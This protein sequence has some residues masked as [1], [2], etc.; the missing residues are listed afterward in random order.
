MQKRI[1]DVL[2]RV[3]KVCREHN[4]T[5]YLS[6][7]T[8]LGAIRHGGFI[9]WDDDA[10][11]AMPREDYERFIEHG[12]EWLPEPLE[13][14]C[15]EKN[16]K[17]SCTFLKIIDGSTTLIERW[18]YNQLGGVYIDIFPYDGVAPQKWR[19][20]VRFSLFR[21]LK[22]WIYLRNRDPYKRGHGYT[23]WLPRILQATVSNEKLQR[24]LKR[25]QTKRDYATSPLVADFD[26]GERSVMPREVL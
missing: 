3:D 9:P 18:G 13:L 2:L 7:G 15:V 21:A 26:S 25:L 19:R 1:L 6:D 17:C 5:Y 14:Y 10:D 11:I 12:A 4:L 16:P 24:M 20:T 22:R 23:S 8:M